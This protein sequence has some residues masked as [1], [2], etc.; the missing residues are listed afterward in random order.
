MIILGK[1]DDN[2]NNYLSELSDEELEEKYNALDNKAD[3]ERSEK[4]LDL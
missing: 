3:N 1:E 4:D 2:L